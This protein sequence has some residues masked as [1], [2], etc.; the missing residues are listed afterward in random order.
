YASIGEL[1]I[2][3]KI[4]TFSV[5]IAMLVHQVTLQEIYVRFLCIICL[6][7]ISFIGGSRFFWRIYRDWIMR[8]QTEQLRTLIIGAGSAGTMVARQLLHDKET[9]LLP[10]GFMDDD[11]K[12]QQLDI[13]GLPVIGGVKDIAEVVKEEEIDHI[14]IAIPSLGKKELSRIFREC[15]KTKVKTKI[16]PLLEDLITGRVSVSEFRDVEVNDL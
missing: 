9:S 11:S 3:L 10:V 15:T 5:F 14:I 13:L 16:L 4:V 7:L 1:V 6:F 8:K 2:I 12:K